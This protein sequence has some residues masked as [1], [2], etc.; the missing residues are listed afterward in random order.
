LARTFFQLDVLAVEVEV[1]VRAPRHLD[2]VD[3]VLRVGVARLVLALLH[4][5][6]LELALVPAGDDVEAEAALADVVG[7]DALLGGDDR[8]KQRRMHGAE[9]GDALGRGEQAGRP[10]DGLER[11]AVQVGVAAVALPAP[12]RQQEVDAGGVAHAGER[13]AVL[14]SSPT[15]APAPAWRS[16]RTSS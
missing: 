4:A 11:L 5:E 1:L 14:P 3:P 8:M 10:G 9:H 12:D 13:E 7:G 2:G 15:S 6:H 16:G